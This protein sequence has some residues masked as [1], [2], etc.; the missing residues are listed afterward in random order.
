[1]QKLR[2]SI[3]LLSVIILTA[4]LSSPAAAVSLEEEI[5]IGQDIDRQILEQIPLSM[6]KAAIEE[7]DR[8]GQQLV[9]G[10]R[11]PEIKYHFRI[12][13]EGDELD[14]FSIPGGYIYFSQRMWDTL[15]PD[16]RIG[17]LAHEISHVDG[18][19]ALD[20]ISKQRK[21]A[22]LTNLLLIVVGANQTWADVAGLANNL[23]SLKYS[24][25]DEELADREAV[26]LA[27]KANM[28]PA[29]ILLAMRKILRFQNEVGGQPPKIF[30]THPPTKERVQKLEQLLQN[31][32]VPV[33]P[34]DVKTVDNPYK[35][36]DITSVEGNT[37]QFTSTRPLENG[38]VVWVMVQGWDYR[39]ENQ[40]SVPVARGM[41]QK[42]GVVNTA[43]LWKM[44]NTHNVKL[45]RSMEVYAP[46]VPD[47]IDGVGMVEFIGKG[48]GDIG[49]LVSELPLKKLD[50]F[51]AL[52]TTWDKEDSK[53]VW[54]NVGY[55]V[56]TNPESRGYV[57]VSDPNYSYAPIGADSILVQMEDPDAAKWVGPII[58]IGRGGETIEVLPNKQLSKDKSYD[59]LYPRWNPNDT[60]EDRLAGRARLQSTGG[61]VVLKMA[62][63][64]LSWDISRIQNG[65]DVYE[66][67]DLNISP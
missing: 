40:T 39:Y 27:T 67:R 38:D 30:S 5:K 33:P 16:E 37:I 20:A 52:Q 65:F 49:K 4:G 44:P 55:V 2:I 26:E 35:V 14:A 19:H 56:V 31:Q 10:T 60:Y 25:G 46:P 50:R 12:L 7:M 8:L 59:V 9:K 41:V 34:E 6:D 62:S 64:A 29:G 13:D 22:L 23:Y 21:R 45:A 3:L 66:E 36:G 17:V 48:G 58:S 24:R 43:L 42:S 32:G 47:P 54:K 51:L 61:K 15:R 53:V 57:S 18:R 28:N 1:M 63:Y 11:R